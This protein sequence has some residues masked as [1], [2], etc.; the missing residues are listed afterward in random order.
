MIQSDLE[1]HTTEN[2]NLIMNL[3]LMVFVVF[4]T[5]WRIESYDWVLKTIDGPEKISDEVK[6]IFT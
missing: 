5:F 3:L 4:A 2:E 1:L 6:M